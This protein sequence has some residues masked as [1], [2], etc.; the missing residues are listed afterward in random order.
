MRRIA[1]LRVAGGVAGGVRGKAL[2][3]RG[4]GR[5]LG[6]HGMGLLQGDEVQVWW[7]YGHGV[8]L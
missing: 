4:T 5:W 6:L 1:L 2:W 7:V 3:G 8:G